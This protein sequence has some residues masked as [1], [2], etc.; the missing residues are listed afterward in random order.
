MKESA[1]VIN[2]EEIPTRLKLRAEKR[3]ITDTDFRDFCN[4]VADQA[5]TVKPDGGRPFMRRV[6]A[7]ITTKFPD[8]FFK[9]DS[10]GN[11]ISDIP[12]KVI[13]KQI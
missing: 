6:A 12:V 9:A 10:S 11:R 1:I 13:K 4:A 2:W 7:Q 3:P 8:S 5:L